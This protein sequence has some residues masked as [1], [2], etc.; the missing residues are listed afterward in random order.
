[1]TARTVIPIHRN[2]QFKQADKD[3]STFL[4][5]GQFPTNVHL[6]L[7]HNKVI[8]DPFIGKN[9]LEVQW[10]GEKA[11]VYKTTFDGPTP[12]EGSK[13]VIV[14]EGLD[15]FAKVELNGAVI[16]ESENMFTPERVDVSSTIKTGANELVIT[17]E[18]AYLKGWKLVEEH[19]KHKW[20][21]WN[22]DSSR[23]AVRKAQYHWVRV[24]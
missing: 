9:E 19:P 15:T 12:S 3:D 2:W 13:T 23:L 21:C 4:P 10:I 20:G 6:D 22:G 8:P 1:M 24:S 7:L 5:V 11:W 14:F 17:F 16:L 18:S